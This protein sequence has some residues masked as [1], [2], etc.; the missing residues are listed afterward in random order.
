[1]PRPVLEHPGP[2]LAPVVALSPDGSIVAVAGR[3]FGLAVWNVDGTERQRDVQARG[4]AQLAVAAN[5]DVDTSA[6]GELRAQS[7]AGA[8]IAIA[9]GELVVEDDAGHRLR[10]LG[11]R[12]R[13]HAIAIDD[14]GAVAL[15]DRD[16][17]WWW[18]PGDTELAHVAA[19]VTPAT[20]IATA[21]GR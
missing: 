18:E 12:H 9:A 15:A 3:D 16:D 20:A 17:V 19:A 8:R 4:I 2:L 5:G 7:A 14:R 11:L 13:P 21:A 6:H 10:T 1:A